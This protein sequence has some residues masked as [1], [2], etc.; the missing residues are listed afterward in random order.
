[1]KNYLLLFF[2]ICVCKIGHGQV[3]VSFGPGIQTNHMSLYSIKEVVKISNRPNFYF[4]VNPSF[5]KQNSRLRYNNDIQFSIKSLNLFR[6]PTGMDPFEMMDDY[7]LL[8]SMHLGF[9]PHLEYEI[10]YRFSI[11]AGLYS[12]IKL[13]E[14]IQFGSEDWTMDASNPLSSKFDF[15]YL[16]GFKG[17]INHYYLSVSYLHGYVDVFAVEQLEIEGEQLAKPPILYRNIQ[18]GIGYRI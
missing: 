3:K 12:S 17:N 13:N 6:N 4:S 10:F 15:G 8:K 14:Q 7:M 5:G 16:L 18:V 1:M 11:L 9:N 2:L